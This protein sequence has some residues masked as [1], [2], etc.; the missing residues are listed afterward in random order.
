MAQVINPPK[1]KSRPTLPRRYGKLSNR[2][3]KMKV[4]NNPKRTIPEG[5]FSPQPFK[6]IKL[7]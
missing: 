7:Y 1:T 4:P 5:K 2:A 6:G 3:K